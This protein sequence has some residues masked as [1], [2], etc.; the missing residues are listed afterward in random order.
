[1]KKLL[2]KLERYFFPGTQLEWDLIQVKRG[3]KLMKKYH[4]KYNKA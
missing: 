4:E 3:I 1:M 2:E